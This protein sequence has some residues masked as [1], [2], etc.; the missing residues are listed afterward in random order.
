MDSFF[1]ADTDF[2]RAIFA[3]AGNKF[4]PVDLKLLFP[5]CKSPFSNCWEFIG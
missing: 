1:S 4:C 3:R 5:S 2:S